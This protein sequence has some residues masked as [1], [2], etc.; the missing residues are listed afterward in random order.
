[1]L[2]QCRSRVV[3]GSR[4]LVAS[5]I[6]RIISKHSANSK[7]YNYVC[8][9]SAGGDF[10]LC[11]TLIWET[12]SWY[13]ICKYCLYNSIPVGTYVYIHIVRIVCSI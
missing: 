2:E 1:M 7:S 13:I 5:S 9:G 6:S 4:V 12:E 10:I 11:E 8:L 3:F